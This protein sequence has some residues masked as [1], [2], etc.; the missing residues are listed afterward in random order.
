MIKVILHTREGEYVTTV[1][2][3][4]MNPMPE[5]IIWGSR[6]FFKP[7]RCKGYYEGLAWVVPVTPIEG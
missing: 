7:D 6:V 3:P 5:I 4:P 2:V 1:D